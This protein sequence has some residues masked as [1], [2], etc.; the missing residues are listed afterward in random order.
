[1]WSFHIVLISKLKYTLPSSLKK[2]SLCGRVYYEDFSLIIGS[3]PQLEVLNLRGYARM[4]KKWSCVAGGFLRLKFLSITYCS[5]ESWTLDRGSCFPVLEKLVLINAYDLNEIPS[6]M[7]EISTLQLIRLEGCTE[8]LVISAMKIKE[9]QESYGNDGL[10]IQVKIRKRE[11]L[12]ER[13]KEEGFSINS[14]DDKIQ[15]NLFLKYPLLYPHN[16][17]AFQA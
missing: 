1:M 10:L 12:E 3:L 16:C 11:R 15:C 13:L 14:K 8:S 17:N 9:E 2:L 4:L 5:L 7:G 6:G